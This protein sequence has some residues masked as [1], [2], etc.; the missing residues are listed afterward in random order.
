MDSQLPKKFIKEQD[1]F[2]SSNE[3][4]DW[5]LFLKKYASKEYQEYETKKEKRDKELL[6]KG[7]IEN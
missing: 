4:E 1:R 5:N 2:F 6:A 3:D 7:I